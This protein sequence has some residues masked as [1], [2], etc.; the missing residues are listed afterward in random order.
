MAFRC[1][2]HPWEASSAHRGGQQD[3]GASCPPTGVSPNPAAAQPLTTFRHCPDTNI[4]WRGGQHTC[5]WKGPFL[6]AIGALGTLQGTAGTE[7]GAEVPLLPP[8]LHHCHPPLAHSHPRQHTV[9]KKQHR[10]TELQMFPTNTLDTLCHISCLSPQSF[11]ENSMLEMIRDK[12]LNGCGPKLHVSNSHFHQN[13]SYFLE[14]WKD[15]L[16]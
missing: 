2:M 12:N 16:I 9:T 1:L 10:G 8:S 11:L 5:L 6:L 15:L 3:P 4:A 13:R 7:S 14:W